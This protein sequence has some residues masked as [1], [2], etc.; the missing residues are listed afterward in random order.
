M[1]RSAGITACCSDAGGLQ[2][3]GDKRRS[4]AKFG[5]QTMAKGI[6]Y[7]LDRQQGCRSI[8]VGVLDAMGGWWSGT[9]VKLESWVGE[10]GREDGVTP[11]DLALEE[12]QGKVLQQSGAYVIDECGSKVAYMMEAPAM[13]EAHK[14]RIVAAVNACAGISLEDLRMLGVGGL[15][16][17]LE[18]VRGGGREESESAASVIV[19][20]ESAQCATTPHART[21]T[22]HVVAWMATSGAGFNWYE[23]S[24]DADEAYSEERRNCVEMRDSLWTAY[25][26]DVEVARGLMPDEITSLINVQ[27]QALCSSSEKR[28]SVGRG[29][30]VAA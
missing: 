29:L 26:F 8:A 22:V 7:R 9:V 16:S 3:R 25:R 14:R 17:L 18:R 24:R 19:D 30:A 27:I 10:M 1:K 13:S 21:T 2:R 15:A 23:A 28:F 6:E 5:E 12:I 4:E 20:E 11:V